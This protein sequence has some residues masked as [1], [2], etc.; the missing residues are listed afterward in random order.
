MRAKGKVHGFKTSDLSSWLHDVAALVRNLDSC[1]HLL[2]TPRIDAPIRRRAHRSA[3]RAIS[4]LKKMLASPRH[5]SRSGQR[6]RCN[7]NA[8]VL[9]CVDL[10][11]L[12]ARRADVRLQTSLSPEPLFAGGDEVTFSRV[13][14][15]IILN[16]IEASAPGSLVAVTTKQIHGTVV[17]RVADTGTGISQSVRGR[18]F[19]RPI[20]TK[21]NGSGRGLIFAAAA[22]ASY[23]GTVAIEAGWRRGTV[24]T[25]QLPA[26]KPSLRRVRESRHR[27]RAGSQRASD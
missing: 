15:N 20:T 12:E 25:L 18:L 6:E 13:I 27:T 24:V 3:R 4:L 23:G 11:R 22:A 9:A 10:L 26:L 2:A 14:Y 5:S 17:L 1:T 7:L 21:K 16:G 19:K 8:S